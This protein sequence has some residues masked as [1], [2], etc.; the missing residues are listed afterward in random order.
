[1]HLGMETET[2]TERVFD[3][4]GIWCMDRADG[5]LRV[6][7]RYGGPGGAPFQW[8]KV[9]NDF[10][11]AKATMLAKMQEVFQSDFPLHEPMLELW[12]CLVLQRVGG[13]L[14]HG[15]GV[16]T[17]GAVHV[18]LGKSGAGKSTLAR[19]LG[20][21]QDVTILSDDRLIVRPGEGGWK[22]YGTPW[23]GEATFCSPMHGPLAGIWFLQQAEQTKTRQ[24]G[25]MQAL[26]L[27]T[28]CVFSAG[29][30]RASVS[31]LLSSGLDLLSHNPFAILEFK[32]E[33]KV[34]DVIRSMAQR[35]RPICK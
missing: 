28:T 14:L 16:L 20:G 29:W 1:M 24:I 25:T 19:T 7:L 13:L 4:G 23:H 15:C 18:F 9:S 34:M 33:R 17:D 32:P 10:T 3:S 11:S 30:D 6:S 31:S 26:Q 5:K 22:V 35:G 2:A 27:L 21:M 8:L 12:T